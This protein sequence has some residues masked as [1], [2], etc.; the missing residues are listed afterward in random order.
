MLLVTLAISW[1][2]QLCRET[3]REPAG[4]CSCARE[5]EREPTGR[6]SCAHETERETDGRCSCAR[7]TEREPASRC[8]CATERE[9]FTLSAG[10]RRGETTPLAAA[11]VRVRLRGSRLA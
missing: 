8:S 11:A 1:S 10:V 7:E 6:C 2:L 9:R 3:E 4:H 5:T